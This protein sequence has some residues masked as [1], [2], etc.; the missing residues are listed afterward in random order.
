[1]NDATE[2]SLASAVPRRAAPLLSWPLIAGL[3][4]FALPLLR[5]PESLIDPDT[6]L[7]LS[8]GRWMIEHG[9]L[10]FHDPFSFSM[11]GAVWVPHE[12]LAELVLAAV[13]QAAGWT[14]LVLLTTACF[15]VGLA[16]FMGRLQRHC[17]PFTALIM[18]ALT[19]GMALPHL[20]I[21]PHML[22][23]PLLVGWS[24]S[25]IAARDEG[26]APSL[27]LLPVMVLWANLHGG[28]MFGLALALFLAGEA[29]V[30]ASGAARRRALLQW[31][32]FLALACLAGLATPNFIDGFIQPFRLMA[33]PTLQSIF[34]E[35]VPP[36]LRKDH[37]LMLWL[38][39]AMALGFSL[40]LKL[41]FTRVVLLLGLFYETLQSTR[42]GD[43]LAWVGPLAVAAMLGP[44]L[45][46]WIRTD[47]PSH[48]ARLLAQLAAP[49]NGAGFAVAAILA[50]LVGAG[51]LAWLPP[52]DEAKARPVAALER[53][54]AMH[55]TG[56]VLNEE[57]FGGY[58]IHAGIPPFIDGRI[59]MY[60]DAFL[61]RWSSAAYGNRAALV[62]LLDQ[63]KITWTLF[64]AD[65]GALDNLNSLPGWRRAYG[66]SV[67]VIHVRSSAVSVGAPED[68]GGD[69]AQ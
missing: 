50:L 51:A 33:M 26:R 53:A 19:G 3:A 21:R 55:L 68:A 63:Y 47:P 14:G 64:A 17:E 5:P 59:E 60:G 62:A 41:P 43:L 8:A 31:G 20:L 49:A 23:L 9:A 67:A 46:A 1:M 24:A 44:A 40:G 45:A 36:D 12:W 18:T 42:H 52:P 38:L 15:G 48:L 65:S 6:Y 16:I 35:W 39:G 58:L 28:F 66:D 2:S 61:K 7:H 27:W 30:L 25:L 11:P 10:P 34:V 4:G 29:I 57:G 22:A 54:R 13:F 32:G 69:R 37:M 56:P